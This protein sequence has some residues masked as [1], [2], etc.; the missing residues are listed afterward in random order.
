MN[1][2]QKFM[3]RCFGAQ[4]VVLELDNHYDVCRA[5]RLGDHWYAHPMGEPY[6]RVRLMPGGRVDPDRRVHGWH[7]ATPELA[8]H[9]SNVVEFPRPWLVSPQRREAR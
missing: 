2:W 5:E 6:R 4:Y 9:F 8:R 1:L 7:S 3:H